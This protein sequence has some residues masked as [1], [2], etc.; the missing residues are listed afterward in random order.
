MMSK[1]QTAAYR[2]KHGVPTTIDKW[3]AEARVDMEEPV[4]DQ[5]TSR[6]SLEFLLWQDKVECILNVVRKP[7]SHSNLLFELF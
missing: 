1:E 3:I 7:V 4:V 5:G 6:Q 2:A